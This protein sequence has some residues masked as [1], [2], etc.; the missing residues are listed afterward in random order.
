MI[1]TADT[2]LSELCPISRCDK[3]EWIDVQIN[4]LYQMT[5]LGRKQKESHIIIAGDFFHKYTDSSTIVNSVMSY[6]TENKDFQFYILYGNHDFKNHNSDFNIQTALLTIGYLPNVTVIKDCESINIE[7]K[8]VDFFAFGQKLIDKG[9]DIAVIHK[10]S[11]QNKPWH[12]APESGNFKNIADQLEN[13]DLIVCG[14][15][16]ERFIANYEGQIFL[17]CGSMTRRKIDQKDFDPHFYIM[18]KWKIDSIPFV[19]NEDVWDIKG[20]KV[21][22][23]KDSAI[24]EVARKF[25]DQVVVDLSF[26]DNLETYAKKENIDDEYIDFIKENMEIK[27]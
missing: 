13:Y 23:V 6:F 25:K 22:K 21:E 19:I 7:G 8:Q 12:D 11:Y 14:D 1:F 15:N 10:F 4:K 5:K 18:K 9:G 20:G 2:H 27:K 16:H 17:N 26:E 24:K 3:N